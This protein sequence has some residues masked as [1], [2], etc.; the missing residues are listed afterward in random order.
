MLK[1]QVETFGKVTQ[2]KINN[3]LDSGLC[4]KFESYNT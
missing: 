2:N 3:N 1:R 4:L